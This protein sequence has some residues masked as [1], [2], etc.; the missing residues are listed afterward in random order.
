MGAHT[1]YSLRLIAPDFNPPSGLDSAMRSVNL[2]VFESLMKFQQGDA[3]KP[4]QLVC[5]SSFSD[6]LTDIERARLRGETLMSADISKPVSL[7]D[8]SEA[9]RRYGRGMQ[10]NPELAAQS[11]FRHIQQIQDENQH[12]SKRRD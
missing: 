12:R 10:A 7:N 11:I 2:N 3:F 8:L 1:I 4:N 6:K 5:F 9:L